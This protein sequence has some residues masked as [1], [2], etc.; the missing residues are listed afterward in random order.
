[1]K[2]L[3]LIKFLVILILGALIWIYWTLV[4]KSPRIELNPKNS[5]EYVNWQSWSE[6]SSDSTR[7]IFVVIGA[8]WCA[9]CKL[10]SKEI[11]QDS[12]IGMQINQHTRPVHLDIDKSPEITCGGQKRRVAHCLTDV[13]LK[14]QSV[15][16]P[17]TL[18]L[19][20][21]STVIQSFLGYS[22]KELYIQ[23]F[24]KMNK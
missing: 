3:V 8:A 16:L 22:S 2:K 13:W 7:P 14:N 1:M 20:N 19:K 9:P 24:N 17:V 15:G 5:K 10:L 4:V 23:N 18:W 12:A 11:F 6:L 21:D